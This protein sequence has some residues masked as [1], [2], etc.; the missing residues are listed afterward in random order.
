LAARHDVSG[1]T[2]VWR[3]EEI[4]EELRGTIKSRLPITEAATIFV[5]INELKDSRKASENSY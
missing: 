2:A 4:I 5:C 3:F 1:F